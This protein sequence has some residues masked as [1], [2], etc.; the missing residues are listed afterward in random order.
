[1]KLKLLCITLCALS[2]VACNQNRHL[3]PPKKSPCACYD[4]KVDMENVEIG[5][6][7]S[8]CSVRK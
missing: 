5:F 3:K 2:F 7:D 1:M 4:L 8:K 6:L